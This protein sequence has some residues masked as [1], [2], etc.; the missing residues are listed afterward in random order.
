MLGIAAL[1][2]GALAG[3]GGGGAEFMVLRVGMVA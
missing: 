1:L 2:L 3:W